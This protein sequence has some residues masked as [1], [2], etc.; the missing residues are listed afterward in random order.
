MKS[1]LAMPSPDLAADLY[2]ATQEMTAA[3]GLP[4][5]RQA[6]ADYL[7]WR[8]AGLPAVRI[9]VNSV[10]SDIK[11]GYPVLM[12]ANKP[13]ATTVCLLSLGFYLHCCLLCRQLYIKSKKTG[14]KIRPLLLTCQLFR[15]R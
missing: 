9:A 1:A 6:I 15:R 12:S 8:R 10:I 5:L 4:A 2:A 11:T 13:T 7:R 3:R 14:N